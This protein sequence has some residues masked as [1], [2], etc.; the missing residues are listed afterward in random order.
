MAIDCLTDLINHVQ[1]NEQ[2]AQVE[3]LT[4]EREE[5]NRETLPRLGYL[6]YYILAAQ[7]SPVSANLLQAI[8]N[9]EQGLVY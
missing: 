5:G 1:A 9:L 8:F 3:A 7:S 4:L 6:M 2:K